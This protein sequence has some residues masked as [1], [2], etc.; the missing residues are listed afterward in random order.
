MTILPPSAPRPARRAGTDVDVVVIGG[1]VNGVGVARDASQRGLKVALFE[2]NDLA[3]GA[4]GNSSG[5]IHGGLRYLT[6]DPHVT[7]KS[8]RDS[9]HIQA[10]APH[11][12]FRIPFLVPFERSRNARVLYNLADGFFEAYDIYQPLK[13]GKPHARLSPDEL[14]RLEPGIHGDLVGGFSFDEWGIDGARLCVANAVDAIER[15]AKVYVGHT[16]ERI[17]RREDT[18]EVVAVRYRDQRTGEG[19]RLRTSA[20]VNATG[21]WSPITTSLAGLPASSSRVRPGKGIHVV[22]DRRLTNYA[23]MARTIDG[24]QIFLEP[25]EN[26]SVVGTTDDDFYGDLDQ[27]RAT[28][29]EVRYLIQGIARV[30]PQIHEARAIGTFAGV[31]PTLYA[32]GPSEDALSRDHQIVD[33]TAHGAPGV[34]SMIGGKLASFRLF[35]EEM[36][37][38]LARRFDLGARCATHAI[39]LPGGDRAVDALALSRRLEIDAVAGRRLV[40]RHGSR[41]LRIE[42][43][44]RERPR[45][46]ATVCPCEPVIEAEVRYVLRHEL[47]RSVA[48]VARRTRLGLGACGGMRCAARCGQIVAQELS[49]PPREGMRQAAEF[50]ARQAVTRAVALGP[51]Q[52]RQ[53]ALAIASVRS[54]LGAPADDDDDVAATAAGEDVDRRASRPARELAETAWR[55]QSS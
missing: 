24:R 54:E 1:G 35:A 19:G 14:R 43:R 6:S 45:E 22:F 52:A 28:S 33:H 39:A 17:E 37:D 48:D 16:V 3:F 7:E 8:C 29:E 44:V 23:I 51:E 15:G 27:V 32:Y 30:F 34:Y 47:A 25:W 12:L 42:E 55:D 4:S 9:G 11:L 46:A 49:L 40:Y 2:R 41:A 53:E 5:M 10:I 36:T 18:G 31:R 38:V 21:A 20:V 13:R 26:M 50:L